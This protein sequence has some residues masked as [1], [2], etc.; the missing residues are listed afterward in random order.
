M[1]ALTG[2]GALRDFFRVRRLGLH[3]RERLGLWGGVTIL[4][5]IY[6]RLSKEDEDKQQPE[7]ESIQNQKSLL[8]HYAVER[9]WDIYRIYCDEDYSGADSQRP[10]FNRMIDAAREKRFQIVLCKTQSRFTRDMELVEKYIH[11]LFPIWGI[12]FIAL[13]DNAD[14]EVKGNKKARQINGLINEWYL[15]DLSE[16]I[17]MVF[18]M[19]RRQGQYIGGF[20]VYGYQKDPHNKNH[21]IID[22]EPAEVV[23]QIFRW[24]LEG[25]GKQNIAFMLN[26]RGIINPA[27]YKLE[28]GW[29]CNRPA[30]NDFGLWNK[31]TV[32]RILHNEMY[33]GVMVQGKSKKVSYKSKTT[34]SLPREQ[35][36]RVEGTHEAVIDPETF[37]AVQKLMDL[38]TRE[39]G[40]G[41]IHPLAGLVKCMDCG[42]T[43]SKTSNG[44]KGAKRVCYLRCKLYADSGE[45]KLCTRHSIRLDRL[46]DLV[47]ERLRRYIQT[48]Y[49]LEELELPAPRDTQRAAL[50]Q[51]QR[52]LTAQLEK[53][54]AALKNLYL[55][56]VSGV[57]SEGQFVELNR[58]FLAE[59]SR[60][61]RRLSQIDGELAEQEQPQEQ[62]DRM[63]KARELLRLDTLPRPLAVM[64]IEKIEIGEHDPD[65]GGQAV[66]IH[67][68]F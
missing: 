9:G 43:M 49:T 5:A 12:R 65:T 41:A 60:L 50:R 11:G 64:L 66:T 18:D 21:L 29:S 2:I 23:R 51:E 16:N 61:E 67:W 22:P 55:D 54:S 44:K 58:D 40:T 36:F 20:P 27:R 25:H 48:Y 63:E 46:I 14:T 17:R 30:R 10:D 6:T 31:T 1:P 13:A 7:S 42:S 62:V 8:V 47:L 39:D 53:R 32:W 3:G 24:A 35:W 52:S 56:K 59:K 38:R 34:V 45:E 4:C 57:L 37:R 33:T 19:K 26:S 68:K 28:R 15:E